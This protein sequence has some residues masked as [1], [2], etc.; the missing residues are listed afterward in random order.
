VCP[1]DARTDWLLGTAVLILEDYNRWLTLLLSWKS[2]MD[3]SH[4]IIDL[5]DNNGWLTHG[6]FI[7]STACC[8]IIALC[9]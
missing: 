3:G 2:I 5:E 9:E 8:F 1:S 6:R 7:T 4:F